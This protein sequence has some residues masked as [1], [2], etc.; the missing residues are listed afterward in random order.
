MTFVARTHADVGEYAQR[1]VPAAAAA[2]G[3][4]DEEAGHVV[5]Q[6][7][8]TEDEDIDGHERHVEPGA[9]AEQERPADPV[10]QHEVQQCDEGE[11]KGELERVEE[12][13][14]ARARR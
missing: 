13:T 7:R 12:H 8:E 2:G 5:D 6:D 3:V 4:L 10:R 1:Q 14:S 11:E 9:R